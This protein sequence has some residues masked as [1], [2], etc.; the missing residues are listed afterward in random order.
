MTKL[1]MK[2]GGSFE[3]FDPEKIRKSI[4][5][6][7]NTA[8]LSPE[9][10]NEILGKVFQN[11]LKFLKDYRGTPSTAEIE[12][13]ILLELKNYAPEV[14]EVWREYRKQKKK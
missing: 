8:N 1:V 12:A 6:A 14:I 4:I 7:L 10:K 2:K 5:S 9:S 11:V 13:K 3:P